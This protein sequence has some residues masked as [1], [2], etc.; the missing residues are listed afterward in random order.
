MTGLQAFLEDLPVGTW[1]DVTT[2]GETF[3]VQRVPG[4]LY[5]PGDVVVS[6]LD[7][8]DGEPTRVEV[9]Q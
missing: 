3:R 5:L 8:C 1:L 2:N 6:V 4:G 9:V 7:V